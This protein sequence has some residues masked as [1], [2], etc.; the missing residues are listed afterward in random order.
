MN[1]EY[2]ASQPLPSTG[3]RSG[4]PQA[5]TSASHGYDA[6]PQTRHNASQPCHSTAR[7]DP[8]NHHNHN[9]QSEQ[10]NGGDQNHRDNVIR[11]EQASVQTPKFTWGRLNGEEFCTAIRS[12]YKETVHWRRNVSK[13]P[14]GK[15]GKDFTEEM[16]RL[17]RS[18]AEASAL[19][20][21]AIMA[22]MVL[23]ALVLQKPSVNSKAKEHAEL[24]IRRMQQWKNGDI[25]DLLKEGRVIQQRLL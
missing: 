14:S 21:I 9:H 3:N 12:A 13:I 11:N 6:L 24:L 1:K 15:S 19:E 5:L 10:L 16:A 25:N 22:A 23:P 20:D 18:F 7:P 2:S 8:V 4:A 17:S